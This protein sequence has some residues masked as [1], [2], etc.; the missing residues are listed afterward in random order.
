MLTD[1]KKTLISFTALSILTAQLLFMPQLL[2]AFTEPPIDRI[3][4]SVLQ[5]IDILN[6]KENI[7]TQ[8]ERIWQ[9]VNGV[10]DFAELSH[11]ALGLHWN[12]FSKVEKETFTDVFSRIIGDLYIKK[13]IENY[14]NNRIDFLQEKID[15]E[16]AFVETSFTRIRDKVN[17]TY[18]MKMKGSVWIVYDIRINGVSLL[19]NYRSQFSKLLSTKT[20]GQVI[21]QLKLN[22]NPG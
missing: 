6:D 18:N 19:K 1:V 17:V 16:K 5:V 8:Q 10:F 22:E 21:E 20:P 3:K 14:S 12:A 9:A 15:G 11:Y 4:S 7:E 2:L 13:I